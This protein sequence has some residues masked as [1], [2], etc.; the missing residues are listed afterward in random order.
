MLIRHYFRSTFFSFNELIWYSAVPT[1][2][3][4]AE[5][6]QATLPIDSHRKSGIT[7]LLWVLAF[8]DANGQYRGPLINVP[9]T[10]A[11]VARA[12]LPAVGFNL[13]STLE[14]GPGP[15]EN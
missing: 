15:W 14:I 3:H 6:L 4:E 10:V 11:G 12:R 1:Y 13:L 2:E 8:I 7:I 5:R 9:L